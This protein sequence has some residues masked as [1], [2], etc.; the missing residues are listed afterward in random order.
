VPTDDQRRVFRRSLQRAREARGLSQ[1]QLAKTI[2]VSPSSV[3]Q[4]ESGEMTPRPEHLAALE[5]ELELEAGTLTRPLGYL[6]GASDGLGRVSVLDALDADPKLT[7]RQRDA[8]ATIYRELVGE[9]D[10]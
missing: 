5:V 9:A 2:G 7:D 4:W 6:P 8:L 3:S 10:G 1:R